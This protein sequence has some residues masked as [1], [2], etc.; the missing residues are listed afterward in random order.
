MMKISM[1]VKETPAYRLTVEK[2]PCAAP[3]DLWHIQFIQE[4]LTD[5]LP[6]R[7]STY[8]FFMT[9]EELSEVAKALTLF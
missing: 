6:T 7:V 5:L 3:A 2:S 4:E 8:E 1:I 9:K